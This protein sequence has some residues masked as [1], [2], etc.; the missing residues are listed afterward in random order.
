MVDYTARTVL[1]HLTRHLRKTF[2]EEKGGEFISQFHGEEGLEMIKKTMLDDLGVDPNSKVYT[3]LKLDG[4]GNLTYQ[5]QLTL[6]SAED[7]LNIERFNIPP[8]TWV[9]IDAI[10][11]WLEVKNIQPTDPSINREVGI[12][13]GKAINTIDKETGNV[14]TF[15][16]I[17]EKFRE[18]EVDRMAFLIARKWYKEGYQ[19][20]F[21]QELSED[22]IGNLQMDNLEEKSIQAV[23]ALGI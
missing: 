5:T 7:Y 19:A 1:G 14:F 3:G 18:E 9:D 20:K 16:G 2:E 15:I 12:K 10:K 22:E 17:R 23:M 6:D 4:E 21:S 11:N 13:R 8:G